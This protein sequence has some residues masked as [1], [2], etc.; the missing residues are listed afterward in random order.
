MFPI[1][2]FAPY[3]TLSALF[4]CYNQMGE[5]NPTIFWNGG[6]HRVTYRNNCNGIVPMWKYT[7]KKELVQTITRLSIVTYVFVGF[8]MLKYKTQYLYIKSSPVSNY[9]V[10]PLV[11]RKYSSLRI[12]AIVSN[13]SKEKKN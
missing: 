4:D 9:G 7:K 5:K 10:V 8:I 2:T 1:S 12:C 13:L 6:N 11:S 3:S